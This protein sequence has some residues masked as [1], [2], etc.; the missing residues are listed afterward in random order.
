MELHDF[1]YKMHGVFLRFLYLY[2]HAVGEG[3]ED[4]KPN[5]TI[6][7]Y[8]PCFLNFPKV[9]I[10]SNIRLR[11]NVTYVAFLLTGCYGTVTC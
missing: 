6:L 1:Y 2:L 10:W 5:I 9:F 4:R 11:G 3:K 7:A 8:L